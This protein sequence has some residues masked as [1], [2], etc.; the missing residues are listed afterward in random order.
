[1]TPPSPLELIAC[2][3]QVLGFQECP[4][5]RWADICHF[6]MIC[7]VPHCEDLSAKHDA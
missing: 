5:T 1:M 4:S 2:C 7:G 6:W 3:C